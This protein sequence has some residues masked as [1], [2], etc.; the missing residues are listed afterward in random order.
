MICT[1][2]VLISEQ[3]LLVLSLILE[4]KFIPI[5]PGRYTVMGGWCKGGNPNEH[6]EISASEYLWYL[7]R[8]GIDIK[9]SKLYAD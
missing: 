5:H 3:F 9:N 1:Q 6:V 2:A 8:S 7:G 4:G